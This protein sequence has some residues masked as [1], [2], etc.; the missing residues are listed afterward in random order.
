MPR[1]NYPIIVIGAGA[2]G[3]VVAIGASR[4]GKKVLLVERGTWGGDCTNFGCIPSKALI[5]CA[6]VAHAVR[7]SDQHGIH[8]S[9]A[10]MS[11]AGAFEYTRDKVKHFVDEEGPDQLAE[12]GV[13]TLTGAARFIDA[14]TLEVE[15]QRVTGANIVIA[16]GSS[17][18]V[19]PIPGLDTTPFLTNET[20]FDLQRVPDSLAIIGGGAIG[21]ELSQAFQRLGSAVTL[22]EGMPHLLIREEPE[23]QALM[24]RH[25]QAEGVV[26][27]VGEQVQ[28]VEAGH[29]HL[30]NGQT[31]SAD[32]ILLAVGRKPNTDGLGLEQVGLEAKK[33]IP[34]DAYGRTKLKHIWAVGD[35]S[36][37][38][39]FTHMAE[40][41]A[42]AVLT[43]LLIPGPFCKKLP[44]QAV[45]AVTF[46]DPE[47]ARIGLTE[48]EARDRHRSLAVY[49]IPMS[50]V[51]RAIAT[52]RTEGFIKVV[53]RKWSSQI[54][55]AT[56]V[57]SGAGELLPEIGLAMKHRI[58]L[59]KLASLIHAYPIYGRGIRQAADLWLGQTVVGTVKGWMGR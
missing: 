56:I 12:M 24:E 9:D 15:G 30:S 17:A 25:L 45:P 14:H 4:A 27:K 55:G 21:C 58:P 52:G 40:A 5:S 11:T 49:T 2:A 3:L 36:G 22:I 44:K 37:G 31:V 59:R 19:P 41:E 38:A 13:E 32:Q 47:V 33:G 23:T 16:T 6:H 48:A 20:I 1:Y 7:T 46:T 28:R 34:V 43:S 18:M 42:R 35:C 8:I 54:L 51:D 50:K 26:I 29:I 53:T 57:G 39:M 10:T